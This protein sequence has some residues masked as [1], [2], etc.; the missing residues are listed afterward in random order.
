MIAFY[1]AKYPATHTNLLLALEAQGPAN[2]LSKYQ[3]LTWVVN[4]ALRLHSPAYIT[5]RIAAANM[6]LKMSD[7]RLMRAAKG[8][9][10]C[11]TTC[12]LRRPSP[13]SSWLSCKV[14]TMLLHD[15]SLDC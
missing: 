5:M 12:N 4:E 14:V 3:Y 11:W 7:G 8:T 6:D 15:A 2:D 10:L 9:E 13:P 1:L